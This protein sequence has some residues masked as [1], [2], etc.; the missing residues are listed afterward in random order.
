[1]G[2]RLQAFCEQRA[3][4]AG[5][6]VLDPEFVFDLTL[7]E[8][9]DGPAWE[10]AGVFRLIAVLIVILIMGLMGAMVIDAVSG[11]GKSGDACTDGTTTTLPV[12]LD[13]AIAKLVERC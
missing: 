8:R 10:D 3:D 1:M 6:C 9:V 7:W 11:A 2:S 5:S 4:D 13:P 12:K